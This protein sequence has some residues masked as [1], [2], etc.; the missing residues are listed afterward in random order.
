MKVV[1][2]VRRPAAR[3]S[4]P[5]HRPTTQ[6]DP[7]ILSA[8]LEPADAKVTQRL[9]AALLAALVGEE[10]A[11]APVIEAAA[12]RHDI[13]SIAWAKAVRMSGEIATATFV[14]A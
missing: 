7:T 14:F 8:L 5:P 6:L 2:T 13:P 12:P 1:T 3:G 10:P 4:E 11:R 9:D